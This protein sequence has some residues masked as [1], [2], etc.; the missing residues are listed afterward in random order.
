MPQIEKTI[1]SLVN[2]TEDGEGPLVDT[3]ADTRDDGVSYPDV[4]LLEDVRF[5]LDVTSFTG[6]APVMDI[7]IVAEVGGNDFVM[8]SFTQFGVGATT[9]MITI[10]NCPAHVKAVYTN[11]GGAITDFDVTIVCI[12]VYLR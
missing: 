6:T 1:L 9:E 4:S 5:F 10:Q 2:A 3:L 7:D 8:G 12:R 11:S